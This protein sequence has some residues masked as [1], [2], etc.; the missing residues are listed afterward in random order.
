MI[1]AAT[2]P[3]KYCLGDTSIAAT[4]TA[5]S[6]LHHFTLSPLH[7]FTT[8]K[9]AVKRFNT[10]RWAKQQVWHRQIA[11]DNRQY[12]AISTDKKRFVALLSKRV[13][14]VPSRANPPF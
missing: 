13:Y 3:Y 4:S 5:T 9:H 10:L 2:M 1:L 7:P 14:I 8:S 6:P 12:A 11:G